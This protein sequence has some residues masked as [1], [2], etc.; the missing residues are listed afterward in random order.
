MIKIMNLTELFSNSNTEDISLILYG[1]LNRI[2]ILVTGPDDNEIE[3]I[4]NDFSTLLIFRNIMVFYTDFTSADD[5]LSF[6]ENEEQDFDIQ[7]NT[8]LCYPFA[9]EKVID[10]V[11][12]FHSWILGCSYT[13]K[14]HTILSQIKEKLFVNSP[15]FIYIEIKNDYLIAQLEGKEFPQFNL[16]FERWILENAIKKTEISIERMRRVISKRLKIKKIGQDHYHNLM[17]FKVEELDLK[18]NIIKKEILDFFQ[19]SRRAFSILNRVRSIKELGMKSNISSKTLLNTIAYDRAPIKRI[20]QFIL[21]EWQ[22]RFDEYLELKKVNNF[23][24]T[25][26][27]LWG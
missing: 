27:S 4:I 15:F 6:I 13:E 16:T 3:S 11:N 10:I 20:L 22:T 7:R 1:L 9:I 26:E 24:D 19:A 25:F 18:S 14:D 23:T 21:E 12:N 17:N 5:Y 8:Y 2:P